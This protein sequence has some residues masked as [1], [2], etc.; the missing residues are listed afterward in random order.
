MK[1]IALARQTNLL[2]LLQPRYKS[3]MIEKLSIGRGQQFY[4]STLRA[5]LKSNLKGS[6][7]TI[8]IKSLNNV[9][10]IDYKFPKDIKILNEGE[11]GR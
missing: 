7:R 8:E 4:N 2:Y 9:F 6:Y 1:F 10:I 5:Q 11:T 3:L